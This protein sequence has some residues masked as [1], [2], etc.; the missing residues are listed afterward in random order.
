VKFTRRSIAVKTMAAVA[1]GA[2]AL[3]A[4]TWWSRHDAPR[5]LN[6]DTAAFVRVFAA[7]PARDSTQTRGELDELLELQRARTPAEVAA[8]RA[9]RKTQI[10][11]FFPVLG[12]DAKSAQH[13][14]LTRELAQRVEDDVRLYV[15][16]AKDRFRRLRPY[17]IEPRLKPCIDH[18]AAD[19]SYPSGH[20]SYGYA[21]AYLLS[22]MVPERR[23][24]LQRRADE[25][26]RQR[27]VCGV[28]FRSDIEAG[29][30]GARWLARAFNENPGYQRDVQAAAAELRAALRLPPLP[31]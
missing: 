16:A 5:Y 20:A 12:L 29:L 28:H 8:A 11:R 3:G 13:L 15:R 2:L 17:E 4:A 9:D 30:A 25:F 24:E 14:R 27:M 31:Q 7:P 22:E 19:L 18:V 23:Q 21:M 10:E 26:A 1:I 6:G